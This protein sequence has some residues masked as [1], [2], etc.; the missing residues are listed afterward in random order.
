M[1]NTSSLIPDYTQNLNEAA[2]YLRLAVPLMTRHGVPA[3]PVNYSIW[4]E[5][6]SGNNKELN[7]VLDKKLEDK[8]EITSELCQKLYSEFVLNGSEERYQRV[9]EDLKNLV[10]QTITRIKSTSEKA[11]TSSSRFT[12]Q[13][14]KLAATENA[15]DVKNVVDGIV[16]E[17][18]QL[19]E[20][21]KEL[22]NKLEETNTEVEQLRVELEKT[23][24]AANTDSLTG[25]LNRRAFDR[26]INNVCNNAN[27]QADSVHLLLLDLDHFKRINDSH[28]HLVGDNVLRYTATLL[29][30]FVK[31]DEIAARYGGEEMAMLLPNSTLV[32]AKEVANQ[33]RVALS[34]SHLQRKDSGEAIGQVTVSIGVSKLRKDDTIE[35][36]IHRADTALYQAKQHG[37]DQVVDEGEL[38]S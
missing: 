35:S 31:E 23:K 21:S 5:Y 17:T 22:K 30:Q 7:E 14:N 8:Q 27:S 26:E 38:Q 15:M 36:F 28:G 2:G 10:N 20:A 19:A 9:G 1:K 11:S 34:K 32:Q 16:A 37:R 4:Y 25:L 3:N 24:Q 18:R 33:I 29:K 6:V 13:S 12:E